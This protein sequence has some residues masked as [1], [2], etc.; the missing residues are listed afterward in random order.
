MEVATELCRE[1]LDAG[2]P[3][4]HFYTLNRSTATRRSTPTWDFPSPPAEPSAALGR[5]PARRI[6]TALPASTDVTLT[7]PTPTRATAYTQP[8]PY[9]PGLDG[10]RAGRDRGHR[11]PR[12]PELAAG[13]F[14]GVEVFFVISGYLISMLLLSEHR[15]SGSIG[16]RHFWFRRARRLLPAVFALLFVVSVVSVLFVRDELDRLKGDLVAA[17]TYTMNWH[18]IRGGRRT[19]TSSSVRRC[20]A[21]CGRWLWRSSS[22]CCGR[23]S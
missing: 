8:V 22:T 13:G 12:Q 18:L 17:L 2:A 1:L 3:G 16:V 19:S 15:R 21:T 20:C 5:T 4:L 23:C 14:L 11:V 6:R 9:L 10:L 7:A